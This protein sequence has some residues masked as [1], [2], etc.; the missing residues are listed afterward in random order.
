MY[1]VHPSID[2]SVDISADSRPMYQL[3]YRLSIG[4]D[5]SIDISVESRSICRLRCASRHIDRP[6]GRASV[7]MSTDTRPICWVIRRPPILYCYLP[8]LRDL[9]QDT[10]TLAS[11]HYLRTFWERCLLLPASQKILCINPA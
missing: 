3:T 1:F 7:D 6:I 10:Y 2:I 4:R 9:E 5:M 8:W 11:C